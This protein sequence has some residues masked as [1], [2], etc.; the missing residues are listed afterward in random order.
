[1]YSS[2]TLLSFE[3]EGRSYGGGVLK[4]ETREAERV[5][6]PRFDGAL[7]SALR[8]ALNHI[9]EAVRRGHPELATRIVDDL[10]LAHSILDAPALEAVR[11]ARAELEERRSLR[12][13]T[14]A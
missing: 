6:L 2:V 10:L 12:G 1:M 4:L 9:D 11:T 7:G 14:I 13:R 8:V 5:D 3:L